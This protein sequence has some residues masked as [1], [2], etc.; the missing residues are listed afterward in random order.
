MINRYLLRQAQS[1]PAA[2]ITTIALN[3]IGGLFIIAQ[4]WLVSTIINQVFLRNAT[5]ADVTSD[6]SSLLVVITLRAIALLFG[7]VSANNIAI[8]IKTD[9]RNALIDHLL[10]LGP[11]YSQGER[12]GELTTTVVEGIESL[13]AYFSQYLPQ[14]VVAVI[15]PLSV[16]LV[17][18]PLDLLSGIVLL[19]TAPLIPIFMI[20]IANATET[21][22]KRQYDLLSRLSAHF[23][24]VLQGLTTLKQLGAS[25]RQTKVIGQYS[26]QYRLAT[27]NVLRVAFLSALV[28]EIVATISTAIVAVEVGLRLLYAKME[29]Q[30]ALFILILAPEFYIPLRMLGLRFHAAASGASAAKRVFEILAVPVQP[31]MVSAPHVDP[32]R[33]ISY[34]DVR[35]TYD[36]S[37]PALDG[38]T[39]EIH[40]GQKVALVGPSGAGKSTIINLLLRFIEPTQGDIKINDQKLSE[41]DPDE[42][43]RMIAWVP[44]TPHL[45]HDSILANIRF[46][47]PDAAMDE[48]IEAAKQAHA[49]DFIT[50]LSQ[51][52]DTRIGEGGA[53]LSGGQAQRIAL[54]R[55]FLKDAPLLLLDEPTSNIDPEL[56]SLL[57]DSTRKILRD[58]T[59]LIIAHRLNTITDADQ[60]IVLDEGRIVES[61]MHNDSLS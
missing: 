30:P 38:I 26:D 25:K 44:Q 52:Y 51:G 12:T 39:F 45:F 59:A 34:E 37:R 14:L 15:V 42:W 40:Q 54:A 57:Q 1:H 24:D 10:K 4:A 11:T 20:L 19:L 36:H 55:A 43:R 48:V 56:E 8:T 58:R 21:L 46:A 6:L 7:E 29:F 17:V 23:L 27:M 18:T 33:K 28:L 13:E 60:I 41:I 53:R 31:K 47:K 5:L 32:L 2:F 3:F 22:T 9:L 49:H 50:S 16:L 61:G 35:F